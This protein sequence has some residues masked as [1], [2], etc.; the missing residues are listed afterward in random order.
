[1]P[2]TTRDDVART[3]RRIASHVR[4]I[5]V[6]DL[7]AEALGT[8][9]PVTLKLESL[10]VTGTFK[11]RGAFALLLGRT[12]PPQGV[13][14]ASGGNFGLAMAHAARCLGH[15]LTVFVPEA[16]P[17]VKLAGIR[18]HGATV[19]VV[20]GP[21]SRAFEAAERHAAS[22]GALL[23]HPY[24][25]PEIVA[26]A[27]TCGLELAEQRP[28][29]DTVLVAVGGG[30]LIGG[31]ATALPESSRV[32][33]VETEGTPTLHASRRAGTRVEIEASGIGSSALGA[34]RVGELAWD[35]ARRRVRD[36]V[37][38]TDRQVVIAQRRLWG[39]AR[40]V[41]EP[42]GAVALAALISGAYRPEPTERVGV[43]VCGGNVDPGSVTDDA[44]HAPR[45]APEVPGDAAEVP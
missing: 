26:G 40:L 33:A 43:I 15:E 3:A 18:A 22:S 31:I 44:G 11:A 24:D 12:V 23:G 42:G 30:G 32:V 25:L 10:Q 16:T 20:P 35:I 37:L 17:G 34:P 5:P 4:R 21:P 14:V 19:E 6:L 29:L 27:G 13:V 39:A 2:R 28:G 36:S 7:E 45:G 8:P 1:M 9:A 38:V 41:A